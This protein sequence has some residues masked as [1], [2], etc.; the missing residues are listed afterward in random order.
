MTPLPSTWGD[1]KHSQCPASKPLASL[2][3]HTELYCIGPVFS[4]VHHTGF[5]IATVPDTYRKPPDGAWNPQSAQK[6]NLRARSSPNERVEKYDRWIPVRPLRRTSGY[7]S[8][9]FFALSGS[10]LRNRHVAVQTVNVASKASMM[11]GTPPSSFNWTQLA[12]CC[13][14][15]RWKTFP[16]FSE[17]GACVCKIHEWW[18]VKLCDNLWQ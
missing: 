8:A 5:Q 4:F 14:G 18:S 9:G 3:H 10:Y 2:L 15:V 13:T 12:S 7:G 17:S 16:F 1:V 11:Q 6:S